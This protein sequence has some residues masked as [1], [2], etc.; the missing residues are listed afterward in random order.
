[1]LG[2]LHEKHAVQRGF[3]GLTNKN[4]DCL[5][6]KYGESKVPPPQKKSR[7]IFTNRHSIT[8]RTTWIFLTLSQPDTKNSTQLLNYQTRHRY[9]STRPKSSRLHVYL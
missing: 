9:H 5:Y 4:L 2:E 3:W 7:K 8:F 1:M 6:L